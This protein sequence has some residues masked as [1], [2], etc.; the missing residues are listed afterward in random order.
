MDSRRYRPA[1][2]AVLLV[3][4]VLSWRAAPASAFDGCAFPAASPESQGISAEA[5]EELAGVVRGYV[6]G[7]HVVGAELLV[8][9]NRRTVL[10]EVFGLKDLPAE[11]PLAPNTIVN[12]R[13]MTKP[14][15]GTAIQML[16][17]DGKLALDDPVAKILP[18]FD[19][20][21]S[22]EITVEHLLTHRGGF[23]QG[24]PPE[25][26]TQYKSLRGLADYWG[27]RGPDQ[28]E[29]G[30]GF[31][32]S[33]PGVDILGA[34]VTEVSG[35][36]L[37]RF[38]AKRLF[39]PAGM[40]DSF[41][42]V[43]NQSPLQARISS[44]HFGS[45]GSWWRY[46][47]PGDGPLAPFV[48]GSGTTWYSTP[49]DYARFLALWLDGG[50][51]GERRLLS[52]A[53]VERAL[54]PRSSMDHP[55]GFRGKRAFYGQ[56]WMLYAQADSAA[57]ARPVVFG[58]AGSDGTWAWAWPEHDLMVLYFTQSRGNRTGTSLERTIER[59]LLKPAATAHAP[60]VETTAS[61]L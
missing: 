26:L 3:L 30:D 43:D 55:T 6:E 11:V 9:K 46:W 35:M 37:E 5:L 10:H 27:H 4:V 47:K 51:V 18:S 33:D 57:E 19:Q 45:W 61:D 23:P 59:L 24:Q 1:H 42:M 53:S 49:A 32:Y 34:I 36:P 22:R 29:P 60:A 48:K 54:T 15:V 12:I 20:D 40:A 44:N 17:D 2:G 13:S 50:V 25:P 28:F 58:H 31:C 41:A 56:L 38:V 16:I 14:I 7:K 39:E 52:E 8:I 21:K